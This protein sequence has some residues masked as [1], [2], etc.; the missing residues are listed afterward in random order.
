MRTRLFSLLTLTI[1]SVGLLRAQDVQKILDAHFDVI[2]QKNLS[3]VK[4][5]VITGKIVQQGME[6]P[7][8]TI[9]KRPDKA[10][11]EAEVQGTKMKQ[12]WDGQ[13]GW[14]IAPWTG[15]ADPIDLSGPDVR[16]L[17]DA[18]DL[19]GP[20][21]NYEEKGSTLELTGKEDLEGT[22]V[23]VLKLTRKDGNIDYFY[24]DAE[25]Y[26]ILKLVSKTI[27]NGSETEIETHMSNYQEV[28][29]YVLPFT[30]EQTFDGQPGLSMN[31]EKVSFNDEIDDGIFKKPVSSE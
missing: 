30:Q 19:D 3:K 6:M 28:E 14:M 7:F 5:M 1:F 20:L 27:I 18:A 16:G 22:E 13:N 25:N 4:T 23:Y 31:F 24:M 8:K 9:T 29:G 21:Y 10:Y 2:G 26:V 11:I 12:G 15:S 17:K